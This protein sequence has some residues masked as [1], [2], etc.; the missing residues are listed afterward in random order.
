MTNTT[1]DTTAP[2]LQTATVNGAALVLTYDE[3]LDETSEPAAGAYSVSV[4]GA[5]GAAPRS[6]D[7][8]G[9]TVTLTLATAA[10]HGQA[11]TV[12]YTAPSSNPVQDANG[13]DAANLS[14]RA[15]IN[16][17]PD[18]TAPALQTATVNGATLV[19][20][21]NEALDGT[22]EPAAGAYSV[23]VDGAAGVAP[24]SVAVSGNTVTLTLATA[25]AHGQ[26]VTVSY[27]APSSNPVQDANGN[28]AANLSRRA[29]INNTPDTTVP[30]TAAPVLQTTAV[31]GAMLVLN[32]NE[33][34]DESSEPAPGAYSVS[35]GGAAGAAPRSVDVSGNTVTLTLATAAAHGQAVTV[36]YT[37]PATNPVQDTA[38]NDAANLSNRVVTNTTPD[39][40]APVLRTATVNGATLVLSYDEALDERSEPAPGA[41]SVSLGGAAGAAPRS[42]DVSGNTVTLTL[43]T[44]AAHGQS[45]TVSYTAPSSNPVQD[46][47]GNDAANLPNR[48]VTNTTPDTTAPVLQTATVNGATLVLSY[49]E[50]LD[51][52]SEP[53]PAA[54][55]VSVGGAAGAAPRSVDVS[56]NTVTLTLATAAAHGQAV[57]VSYTAPSSNPVQDTAGN[58]AANLPNRVVTNTTPDT[59]APVLQT[60]TVNGATLVLSYDK[61]LDGTSEPAPAAYSVSVGGAA[62]AA[63]RS[64]DVSGNTVT[65]TLTTAAAHGQ[66]VTVSYT[67][68][69]SN[70]VQDTA[71]NDAAN[72]PNRVVTNTTPDTAAPVLQ[73]A[74]VNGATLVLSYDK[75]LDGTS[76]PAPG[77]YSVSVGGA[78][79]A[80]PR[81]VN[82]SG[83]TVTLTLATAATHGQSVTV[84][85][86]R[87]LL[88]PG[89]RT[90]PATTPPTSRTGSSATPR[91]TPR[92]RCC[93]PRR[94]TVPRSC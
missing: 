79:G 84:S 25:A 75:A 56:G 21:Y 69:S 88:Q 70:P 94:S 32:Y 42:V 35:L 43:A 39:T 4:G 10:A 11:V 91:R 90:R 1:P 34:L 62:G 8:S 44:A 27:T 17:T 72:L 92:R 54:Y 71:G 12:S 80:A 3:A 57:T 31:N 63:P 81:S 67:A 83:N 30:D 5:A 49:D 59:T 38:G 78:A 6:V 73:T 29:A 66:S 61:A 86:N 65:L 64:V 20:T 40:T 13:N 24:R 2:A 37:A 76:E 36:S 50:A 46:T 60:A 18:T 58:D 51:G 47:A 16:N 33:A 68:P 55:S 48:V 87:A 82:V 28:D 41:Y 22:S 53:A 26:A 74:T 7:V 19:L 45:V 89:P 77:A 14:R 23:S 52:T 9:N 85:Y 93:R 15:A